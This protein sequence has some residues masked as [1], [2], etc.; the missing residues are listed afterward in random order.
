MTAQEFIKNCKEKG[1]TDTQAEH[2][3]ELYKG[4]KDIKWSFEKAKLNFNES[5]MKEARSAFKD[6]N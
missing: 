5:Q 1:L 3:L 2:C 6:G 4:S